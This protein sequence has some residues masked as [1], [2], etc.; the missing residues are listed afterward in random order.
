[1]DWN[2]RPFRANPRNALTLLSYCLE[3]KKGLSLVEFELNHSDG[4]EPSAHIWTV[5]NLAFYFTFYLLPW[6]L[7]IDRGVA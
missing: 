3:F 7:P 1:M 5:P 4:V 2:H 6:V